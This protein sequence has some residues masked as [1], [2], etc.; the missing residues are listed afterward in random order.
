MSVDAFLDPCLRIDSYV[1]FWQV[2][3]EDPIPLCKDSLVAQ[4]AVQTILSSP[5]RGR[6]EL[7]DTPTNR[8][9][10]DLEFQAYAMLRQLGKVPPQETIDCAGTL[11]PP[12]L[13]W[14]KLD[15]LNK[16]I[17]DIMLS[18]RL[19]M[20]TTSSSIL[21]SLVATTSESS[22]LDM[23]TSNDKYCYL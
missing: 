4:L 22:E 3:L 15:L 2:E 12:E 7:R 19:S 18:Y 21:L 10:L 9:V 16:G 14:E 6:D 5:E 23:V 20:N 11:F 1:N 8:S 13:A 17:G